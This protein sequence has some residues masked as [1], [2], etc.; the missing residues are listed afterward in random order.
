[1]RME[2]DLIGKN[3]EKNYDHLLEQLLDLKTTKHNQTGVDI[4]VQTAGNLGTFEI[5][6]VKSM[7]P[8]ALRSGVE[9]TLRICKSYKTI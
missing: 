9:S 6:R 2:L 8:K 1:M 3:P 5:N 7:L 4:K